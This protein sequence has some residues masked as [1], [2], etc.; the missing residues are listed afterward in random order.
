MRQHPNVTPM[1]VCAALALAASLAA[2]PQAGGN[3]SA[4]TRTDQQASTAAPPALAAGLIGYKIGPGDMLEV[5]VWK[6]TEAS[7]PAVMVRSDGRVSLP[8]IKEVDVVGLTPGELERLLT[9]RFARFINEPEV[10]VLVKEVHSERIYLV[11]A[12]K[13]EGSIRFHPSMTVLQALAE[14][15]GLTDFARKKKIYV[16]RTQNQKQIRIPFNYQDVVKGSRME[17]NFA[18][19]PGDTIVVP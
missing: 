7:V 17:Q 15:G 11:G 9:A 6:E 16:L 5:R 3:G 18:V 12:V 1:T 4:A 14:G 13:K 8:M 10:T 19:A 2:A